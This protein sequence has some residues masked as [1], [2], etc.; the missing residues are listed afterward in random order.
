MGEVGESIQP[1]LETY[2]MLNAI[3]IPL[4]LKHAAYISLLP[5][6]THKALQE[7]LSTCPPRTQRECMFV[8][9]YCSCEMCAVAYHGYEKILFTAREKFFFASTVWYWKFFNVKS[10]YAT[11]FWKEMTS[12]IGFILALDLPIPDRYEGRSGCHMS[13]L[14]LNVYRKA[15]SIYP[16]TRNM[17]NVFGTTS[18]AE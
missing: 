7:D 18:A 9:Y 8:C 6:C 12:C 11:G 15:V 13:L 16:C 14:S 17:E 1:A 2:M 3:V 10:M 5:L 4:Q